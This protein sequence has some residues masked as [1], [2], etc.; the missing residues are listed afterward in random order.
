M[1]VVSLNQE[2]FPRAAAGPLLG[3]S[4]PMQEVFRLID[5]VGPTEA[6]VLLTGESG[7]GK[8]LAAQSIHDRSLRRGGPFLAINCGAIPPD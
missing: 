6:S 7:S 8:E 5:R 4:A 2:S 3:L 1:S